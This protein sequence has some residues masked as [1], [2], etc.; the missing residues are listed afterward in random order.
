VKKEGY[1]YYVREFLNTPGFH[2]TGHILAYVERTQNRV[3][4]N[5]TLADCSRQIDLC[6]DLDSPEGRSN[7]IYKLDLLIKSLQQFRKAF[8]AECAVQEKREAIA[9][10]KPRVTLAE[11]RRMSA[12]EHGN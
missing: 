10:T 3:D 2:S 7:S 5:F 9:S 4:V 8:K 11:I 12:E 6:F 1:R